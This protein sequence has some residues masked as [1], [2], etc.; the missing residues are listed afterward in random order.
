MNNQLLAYY[1]KELIAI[2]E[3]AKEFATQYPK[4]AAR[5]DIHDGEITDPYVE[6]LL[7]GVSFLTART[8]LKIDAEYASFVKRI[9]EVLYPQFLNQTP[10]SAIV[11]MQ[12]SQKQTYNVLYNLRR[13]E[14][15]QSLPIQELGA[16]T[17]CDFSITKDIEISPLVIEKVAYTHALDYLPQHLL[18]DKQLASGHSALRIDFSLNIDGA[19]SDLIPENLSLYLG[20]ELSTSSQLLYLLLNKCPKVFCHSYEQPHQWQIELKQKPKHLG[21]EDDEALEF[22]LNKNIAGLRVIQEYIQL[23]E[24]FV[25]IEQAGVKT[26]IK[27]AEQSG[28]IGLTAPQI[29][30]IITDNGVN[31]RIVGFQKR[32]FSLSFVFNHHI[33][34]IQDVLKTQDIAINAVPITNLFKKRGIRFVID[35]QAT[36]FHV[37]ADR[38]QP[39][40]YEVHSIESVKGYD[41][42]NNQKVTFTPIYQTNHTHQP[43][44]NNY[45]FFSLLRKSR[46]ASDKTKVNGTRSSYTGSEAYIS[47]VNQNFTLLGDNDIHQLAIDA[48]CTNRDLPLLMSRSVNSDFLIG[49][50]LP[51]HSIKLLTKITRPQEAIDEYESLWSLLNLLNLNLLSLTKFNPDTNLNYFKELLLSF[52]QANN[53][54]FKQQVNAIK[55]IQIKPTSKIQRNGSYSGLVRGIQ[56]LIVLDDGL[57]GGIHPYLF[58]SIL[59]HYLRMS[60]SLN[61]YLQLSLESLQRGDMIHW[62]GVTGERATL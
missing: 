45:A 61:S 13:E 36:E 44:N 62:D 51:V 11:R 8:Q 4:V 35:A 38:T 48:W 34:G 56:I 17:T 26:A 29:E 9:L 49:N 3:L 46:I 22:N 28:Y 39:L 52:P 1:N 16:N 19:I 31:K 5:L 25:F 2:R 50:A 30:E 55:S 18:K 14:T 59:N 21:F 10:A 42:Q 20:S 40:N 15:I 57:M 23:P 60:V 6:R 33:D 12:L 58:G 24:K 32:Y 47:L 37:V 53:H 7:E 54:Q 43:K 41:V 27:T